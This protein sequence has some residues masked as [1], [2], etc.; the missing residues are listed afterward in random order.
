MTQAPDLYR[1]CHKGLRLALSRL[2]TDLGATDPVDMEGWSAITARWRALEETLTLHLRQEDRHVR[3]LVTAADPE[4]A[5]QLDA[6]HRA[7]EITIA[8]V[9]RQIAAVTEA[10]GAEAMRQA[11][12]ALY[13][14]MGGLFA[15]CLRH[16][17]IEEAAAMP[18]LAARH[19]H[20]RLAAT[21]RAMRAATPPARRMAELALTTPALRPDERAELGCGS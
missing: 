11:A 1:R 14:R 15:D 18:A 6:Q 4:M 16:F 17:L 9:G 3:P 5:A 10:G 12:H 8:H 13:L 21:L 19:S 2:L 20:E 7:L